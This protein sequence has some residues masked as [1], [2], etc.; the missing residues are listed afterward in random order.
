MKGCL[1]DFECFV[2]SPEKIIYRQLSYLSLD[3]DR[4]ECIQ[5]YTPGIYYNQLSDDEKK[6]VRYATQK[7]H[8]LRMA[9]KPAL[10]G[11]TW[12]HHNKI[13][14]VLYSLYKQY[15]TLYY[16]GGTIEKNLCSK[17][18]IPCVDIESEYGVQKS[19][20]ICEKCPNHDTFQNHCSFCD[21]HSYKKALCIKNVE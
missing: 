12:L 5:I 17:L 1:I 4:G 9:Y 6:T 8:G 20:V 13:I 14:S 19:E 2:L 10:N 18:N 16:K 7:V 21:V 11:G 3:D 15:G